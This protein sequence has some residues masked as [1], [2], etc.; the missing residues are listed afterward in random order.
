MYL[1]FFQ[2]RG[3]DILLYLTDKSIMN[4][5]Y[6]C[7]SCLLR[8]VFPID[9]FA[10]KITYIGM[11]KIWKNQ[12]YCCVIQKFDII[13]YYITP[14]DYWLAIAIFSTL[15]YTDLWKVPTIH[16]LCHFL[17]WDFKLYFY[18]STYCRIYKMYFSHIPK[19]LYS[20]QNPNLIRWLDF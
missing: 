17:M 12:N 14:D 8:Y 18:W 15:L 11:V 16:K 20:E 3:Y 1:W 10:Q 5:N 19:Y 2:E 13:E 9:Y 6:S 7:K 4:C